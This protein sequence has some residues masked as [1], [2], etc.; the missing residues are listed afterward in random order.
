MEG[1]IAHL[2]GQLFSKD[3]N[4]AYGA[5]QALCAA[6]AE[7]DAVY[8]YFDRFAGMLCGGNSYIRTRGLILIAANARWDA[9]NKLEGAL[10]DCLALILDEKPIASRQCVKAL[11]EIARQK[12]AL[13][14][15]IRD[16][17]GRADTSRYTDTMRP[18][19]DKDIRAAIKEIEEIPE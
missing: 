2:V 1:N 8:P 11:P 14:A 15:K 9:E 6:S 18:L 7:S 17:L 16:A 12:P 5:L 19:I 10:P 3:N 13:R 4:A